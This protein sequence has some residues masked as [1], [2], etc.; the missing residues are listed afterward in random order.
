MSM[1]STDHTLAMHRIARKIKSAG[2]ELFQT[3]ESTTARSNQASHF[4]PP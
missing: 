3:S 1:L 2:I 4:L